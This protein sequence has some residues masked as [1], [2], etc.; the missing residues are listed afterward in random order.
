VACLLPFIDITPIARRLMEEKKR[1]V[2]DPATSDVPAGNRD[3]VRVPLTGGE[4][5]GTPDD[6]ERAVEREKRNELDRDLDN[7]GG[8]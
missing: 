6:A 3:H 2:R 8:G 4:P 5:L 7:I 1:D